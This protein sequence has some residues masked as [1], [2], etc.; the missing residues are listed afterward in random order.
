MNLRARV[1]MR[2]TRQRAQDGGR[3][4]H[5]Q[6]VRLRRRLCRWRGP[7]RQR[8]GIELPVPWPHDGDTL[9][10]WHGLHSLPHRRRRVRLRW[11]RRSSSSLRDDLRGLGA[12]GGVCGRAVRGLGAGSPIRIRT[13]TRT[14][15][16]IGRSNARRRH[17]ARH[18]GHGACV[19]VHHGAYLQR[20]GRRRRL[21]GYRPR[22]P[23][24]QRAVQQ[25]HRRAQHAQHLPARRVAS[26][27]SGIGRAVRVM[28][29]Q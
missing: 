15:T 1:G 13:R 23:A 9:R 20:G 3:V 24:E 6:C 8:V 10:A 27:G 21:R 17:I 14:C 7:S 26:G 16:R 11:Q 28:H 18:P 29:R 5:G 19:R 12:R 2:R 22:Q 4:H 25:Q